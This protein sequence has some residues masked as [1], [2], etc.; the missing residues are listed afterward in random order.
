[1]KVRKIA[2]EL[3][4]VLN[5]T[6]A[7]EKELFQMEEFTAVDLDN[8]TPILEVDIYC[9]RNRHIATVG[10]VQAA[11]LGGIDEKHL[12]KRL[13]YITLMLHDKNWN[14]MYARFASVIAKKAQETDCFL[15]LGLIGKKLDEKPLPGF[16]TNYNPKAK[17]MEWYP[18]F[19]VADYTDWLPSATTSE[20]VD[21]KTITDFEEAVAELSKMEGTF[22]T[23]VLIKLAKRFY[24][25]SKLGDIKPEVVEV[26][27]ALTGVDVK[28]FKEYLIRNDKNF[29]HVEATNFLLSVISQ[30]PLEKRALWIKEHAFASFGEWTAHSSMICRQLGMRV[31]RKWSADEALSELI[32]HV[33]NI[34]EPKSDLEAVEVV[35]PKEVVEVEVEKVQPKKRTVKKTSRK[36]PKKP[37]VK[38]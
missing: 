16:T 37:T 2:K 10:Q 36:A 24:Q 31:K 5:T 26:V 20:E 12:N 38:K 18:T 7:A 22:D 11:I 4:D 19:P 8:T 14:D 6:F 34:I 13:W 3:L 30:L 35:K 15:S 21:A 9:K 28:F 32:S 29:E 27:N 1:M 33:Q 25:V 23:S 17:C